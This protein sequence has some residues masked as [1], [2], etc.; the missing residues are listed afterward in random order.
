MHSAAILSFPLGFSAKL[1]S[2][3]T[4]ADAHKLAVLWSLKCYCSKK[5][6]NFWR[7][8]ECP[9]LPN[10]CIIASFTQFSKVS[11]TPTSKLALPRTRLGAPHHSPPLG[12]CKTG[13]GWR[14]P[15]DGTWSCHLQACTWRSAVRP[16]VLGKKYKHPDFSS[17]W[18][19]GLKSFVTCSCC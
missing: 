2:Q 15:A 10:L 7:A 18:R 14:T 4:M 9:M 8:W 12:A 17:S 1:S 11:Y 19:K 13:Q 5:N 16:V 6:I 3:P